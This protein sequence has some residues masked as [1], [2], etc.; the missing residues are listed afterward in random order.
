MIGYTIN[1]LRYFSSSDPIEVLSA[2]SEIFPHDP[3]KSRIDTSTTATLSFPSSVIGTLTCN[4]RQPPLYG[5]IPKFPTMNASVECEGGEIEVCNFM[6]PTVY[7]Y[8]EIAKRE[9]GSGEERKKR[10][11]KVYSPEDANMDWKGEDW[12]TT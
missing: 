2:S 6:L 10:V 5:F 9:S 8:I 12:W 1:L 7:H 11:E 4:L 3:E